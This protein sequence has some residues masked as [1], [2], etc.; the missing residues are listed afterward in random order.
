MKFPLN[1]SAVP[2]LMGFSLY[3]LFAISLHAQVQIWGSSKAG[4]SDQIGTIFNLIDD[5]S[6]YNQSSV[7][8]NNPQG[9]APRAAL[10]ETAEGALIGAT[11]TGGL[12]GAGTLFKINN[13]DFT[14]I[15]DLDPSIHGS[16]IQTD[17]LTLTD[18]TLIAATS[19]G[20]ANG[21]GAILSFEENGNVEVLFEFN[22]ASTGVMPRG[23]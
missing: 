2:Y 8:V 11:S 3:F 19:S 16:N 17:L 10:T 21:A 9:A 6:G 1:Y 13:G 14:K 20:A 22:S 18:G 12:F 5:G 15:A 7:F 23:V 4:G